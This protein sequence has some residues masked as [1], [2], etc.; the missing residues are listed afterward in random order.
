MPKVAPAPEPIEGVVEL[1]TQ[2]HGFLRRDPNW[3]P[4]REDLFVPNGLIRQFSLGP[5]TASRPHGAPPGKGQ[6]SAAVSQVLEIEGQPPAA[7][8][9]WPTFDR[10]TAKSPTRRMRLER[11]AEDS[12]A[13][14][15]TSSPRSGSASAG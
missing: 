8:R 1:T 7:A 4:S 13:G 3:I 11:G 12:P 15:S 14:S 10:L 2:G 6:R 5:A 9:E